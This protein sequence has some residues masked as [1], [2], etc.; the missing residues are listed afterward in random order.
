MGKPESKGKSRGM[1][2]RQRRVENW[3]LVDNSQD[4]SFTGQGF[5]TWHP[6]QWCKESLSLV[7]PAWVIVLWPSFCSDSRVTLT[8]FSETNAS[9]TYMTLMKRWVLPHNH[10]RQKVHYQHIPYLLQVCRRLN[11]WNGTRDPLTLVYF[12]IS[13]F[14][15]FL[16]LF[17]LLDK[18]TCISSN[19]AAYFIALCSCSL[20]LQWTYASLWW[21]QGWLLQQEDWLPFE[22]KNL[23]LHSP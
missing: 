21:M 4:L 10:S 13:R 5:G 19:Q 20:C 8:H 12:D 22:D 11:S 14:C 23:L 18:I 7:S 6:G 1:Q 16:S 15:H 9:H 2:F 17:S 3:G